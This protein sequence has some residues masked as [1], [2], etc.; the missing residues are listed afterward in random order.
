MYIFCFIH[1]F[2][3]LPYL[4]NSRGAHKPSKCIAQSEALSLVGETDLW[5]LEDPSTIH[6]R[7]PD[8]L[9]KWNNNTVSKD[10]Q[11]ALH[12]SYSTI[13]SEI[14]SLGLGETYLLHKNFQ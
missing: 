1:Q 12:S 2:L 9:E 13:Y 5:I 3:V 8:L 7:I 10:V 4:I 11:R 6:G 14:S